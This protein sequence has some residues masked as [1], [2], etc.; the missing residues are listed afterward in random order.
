MPLLPTADAALNPTANDTTNVQDL[1]TVKVPGGYDAIRANALSLEN[2][3]SGVNT[4]LVTGA[5]GRVVI[6]KLR[7][8]AVAA[9][10]RTAAEILNPFSHGRSSARPKRR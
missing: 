7:L 1:S 6:E 5:T 3:S 9:K 4:G 10:H 2:G 8:V